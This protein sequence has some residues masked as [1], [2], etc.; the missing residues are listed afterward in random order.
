VFCLFN[1]PFFGPSRAQVNYKLEAAQIFKPCA[2]R[3]EMGGSE[4]EV[5]VVV[6]LVRLELCF[7]GMRSEKWDS[8]IGKCMPLDV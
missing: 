7:R 8:E 6:C 5:V 3:R 2:D 1:I 4:E